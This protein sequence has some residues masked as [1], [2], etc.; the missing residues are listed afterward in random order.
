MK[1]DKGIAEFVVVKNAAG[2]ATSTT[3]TYF[4]LGSDVDKTVDV[5][6]GE[7]YEYKAVVNGELTT[8][9]TSEKIA[10]GSYK[11]VSSVSVNEKGVITAFGTAVESK[12]ATGTEAYDADLGL[13][14]FVSGDG[15]GSFTVSSDCAVYT[16]ENGEITVGSIDNILTDANDTVVYT[17]KDGVVT[18]VYV[19]VVD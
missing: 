6:D 1:A 5:T 11:F 4:V 2:G 16:V 15:K 17:L 18:S 7:Y 9:K 13:V 8:V 10:K 19:T 14:K 3:D 12:K